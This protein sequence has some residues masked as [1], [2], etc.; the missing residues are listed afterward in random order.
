[1]MISK[2]MNDAI[3][4]QIGREFGASLQYVSIAAYLH[5]EALTQ[6]AGFFFKQAEEERDHAMKLVKYL[7]DAG[8]EVQIPPVEAPKSSFS[9]VEETIALAVQW[10]QDVTG[11][12]NAL[13]DV[14]IDEKDYLSRQFLDWFV[15]EQLEEVS[16][17]ENLLK[18][19]QKAG[20]RNLLMLE[21][22]ISHLR[23]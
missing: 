22:Y 23:E 15:N 13:M 17:M 5:S 19:V 10:E 6:F 8:G 7:V 1:M 21:A 20:D 12:I 11:Y 18:V 9:S 16:T 2:H 4:A 14:A 3:N